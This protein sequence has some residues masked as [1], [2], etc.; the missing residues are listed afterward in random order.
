MDARWGCRVA[1]TSAKVRW[2]F[3]EVS[4]RARD[5]DVL[6]GGRKENRTGRMGVVKKGK[7]RR[8]QPGKVVGRRDARGLARSVV[9]DFEMAS[10]R[11]GQIGDF[12][13]A[14][15]RPVMDGEFEADSEPTKIEWRGDAGPGV[16][17][18]GCTRRF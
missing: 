11:R 12:F 15:G 10:M 14:R 7:D 4:S 2:E 17:A 6:W 18:A 1:G 3:G 13:D 8:R 9:G 5:G 16:C